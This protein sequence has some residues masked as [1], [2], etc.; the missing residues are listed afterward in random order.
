M[1]AFSLRSLINHRLSVSDELFISSTAYAERMHDL[2]VGS[3]NVLLK[4]LLMDVNG[5]FGGFAATE[6]V[7]VVVE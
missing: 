6:G 5:F 2:C 1:E 4:L 3:I 7:P